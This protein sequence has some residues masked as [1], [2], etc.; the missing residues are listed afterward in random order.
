MRPRSNQKA[1]P[2]LPFVGLLFAFGKFTESFLPAVTGK[3]RGGSFRPLALWFLVQFHE[4]RRDDFRFAGCKI[5]IICGYLGQPIHVKSLF[6]KS[7]KGGNQ[8][9]EGAGNRKFV[10]SLGFQKVGNWFNILV[11][12]HFLKIDEFISVLF[13]FAVCPVKGRVQVVL[14]ENSFPFVAACSKSSIVFM[15][16]SSKFRCFRSVFRSVVLYITASLADS[17]R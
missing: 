13:T 14:T 17:Q 6:F 8:T 12:Y 2:T 15:V 1:S 4:N 5:C 9:A 10:D 3:H 11:P 16:F 7:G